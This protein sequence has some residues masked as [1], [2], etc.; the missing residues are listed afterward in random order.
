MSIVAVAGD[1]T[2]T[3]AIALAA[4]WPAGDDSILVEADPTG[5]DLAAW[6]DLPVAPSLSTVVTRVLDGAWSDIERHT[7]LAGNGLRI[8]PAPARA[9]EAA[10]AVA[11]SG[12]SIVQTL[13]TVRSPITIADVGRL[14]ATP[15]THPFVGAATA[16]V[17]VHRQASQSFQAAAVRLRRFG[18]QLDVLTRT[19]RPVVAVVVGARPFDLDEIERFLVGLG[20][21]V[22]VV[23]LPDD[24]LTA[25]VFAG[26][27]GVSRRRLERLPLMRA[28]RG[29]ATAVERTVAT[30]TGTLWRAV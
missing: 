21:S 11:E 8:L 14:S 9:A 10:G 24:P 6:F 3:T 12:R 4:G 19:N 20:T 27:A 18:D 23:G 29:L 25:A 26:R 2:T 17:A 15:A 30:P 5:G 16:I 22:P 1:L 28:A 13:A 7:R